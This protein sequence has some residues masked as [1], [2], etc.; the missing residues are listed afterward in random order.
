MVNYN[1]RRSFYHYAPNCMGSFLTRGT[2]LLVKGNKFKTPGIVKTIN[3]Q[4]RLFL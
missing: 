3:W 4:N 1:F 2:I